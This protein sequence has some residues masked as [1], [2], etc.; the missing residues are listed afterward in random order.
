[1]HRFR[2]GAGH[3]AIADFVE[4]GRQIIEA[5]KRCIELRE[6]ADRPVD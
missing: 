1:L 2:R 5:S 4:Q 6:F 3:G